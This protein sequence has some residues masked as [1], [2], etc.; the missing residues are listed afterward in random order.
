MAASR[1][2]FNSVPPSSPGPCI[3]IYGLPGPALFQVHEVEGRVQ[4]QHVVSDSWGWRVRNAVLTAG[5]GLKAAS[6]EGRP[7]GESRQEGGCGEMDNMH[8]HCVQACI[9]KRPAGILC[10]SCSLFSTSGH[11][12]FPVLSAAWIFFNKYAFTSIVVT[13]GRT[14][15]TEARHFHEKPTHTTCAF[16]QVHKCN[17]SCNS[18]IQILWTGQFVPTT[19]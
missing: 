5:I 7:E 15:R 6:M 14:I 1:G 10:C 4:I 2:A 8:A 12:S 17:I 11:V 9:R 3:D 18:M 19:L 13:P 16:T